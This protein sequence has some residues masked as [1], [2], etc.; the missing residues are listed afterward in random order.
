M[1]GEGS[2]SGDWACGLA[3]AGK[4]ELTAAKLEIEL[5]DCYTTQRHCLYI[6]VTAPSHEVLG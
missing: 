2:K 5:G 4:D 3:A 1:A 6:L